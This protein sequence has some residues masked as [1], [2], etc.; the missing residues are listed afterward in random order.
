MANIKP[1]HTEEDHEA[2]LVRIDELMDAEAGSPEGD[3]LDILVTLVE[4]YE[5]DHVPMPPPDP[6]E[7]IRFRMDQAGLNPRDM[8]PFMGSRAKVHEVLSGKRAIS[9]PMARALH[10]HLGIPAEVLLR[11]PGTRPHESLNDIDPLR[12]PIKNMVKLGWIKEGRNLKDKAGELMAEMIRKA[13]VREAVALYRK[14]DSQRVNAKTDFYALEA[15]CWRVMGLANEKPLSC[16]YV[17]GSVTLKLLRDVA[18]LS[19]SE[20]GPLL[21]REF[22]ADLGIVLEVVPHLPKTYLDGAALRLSDGRPAIGL[23]LR[24]DRIDNFW[25]SLLHELAHI[26]LHLDQD[27]GEFF[28]DD[29][30]LRGSDQNHGE[31]YELEADEWANEALIPIETWERCTVHES[32]TALGVLNL[33]SQLKIHPAIVAGRIRYENKNYRL[34]S[35][36]VGSGAVR[37]QFEAERTEF[38]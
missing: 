25:F 29:F 7:A 3:E 26:G 11:N 23:T 24:Y 19:N 22:L 36:F 33:A 32:P 15:W 28:A 16:D 31:T 1:I 13:G 6:I 37:E 8:I 2:S 18:Q 27:K 12:Y 20:N 5:L 14:N 21:A 10:E 35:Q 17:P 38:L 34:L 30:T 4:S 9:M